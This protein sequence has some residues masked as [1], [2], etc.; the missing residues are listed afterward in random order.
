[1][2]VLETTHAPIETCTLVVHRSERGCAMNGLEARP[3]TEANST[4]PSASPLAELEHRRPILRSIGDSL[5]SLAI[6]I[7]LV[8]G[9]LVEGYLISTGSM[10]PHL[11]GEH[12]Q[13]T[14]SSCGGTFA[15]GTEF[16]DS[17]GDLG[18]DHATCPNCLY[19]D[20]DLATR[21]VE[22]GDHLLV[23]KNA[24]LWR[25]PRRW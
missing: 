15:V 16:D 7:V 6:A 5:I 17:A 12:K 9:F 25:E 1:M 23:W 24:F 18:H 22:R 4:A 3:Q 11:Y 20:I 21:P 14:C 13:V 10:A 19:D 2:S 8:R